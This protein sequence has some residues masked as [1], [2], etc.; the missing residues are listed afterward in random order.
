[1]N[2]VTQSSNGVEVFSFGD[3]EPVL[4]GRQIS[5]LFQSWHNG[6]YYEPPV[7][8][9]GLSKARHANSF[10]ESA[11]MVK[12][13][14]LSSCYKGHKLLSRREFR[15]LA[16]DY[17]AFGNAYLERV[18]NGLREP[19]TLTRTLAKM[20]RIKKDGSYIFLSDFQKEHAFKRNSIFHFKEPDLN[21][22]IYGVPQYL[23]GLQSAFLNEEATLFR[24]RYYQN[25]SHAGFILHISDAAMNDGDID[26]I[27]QALK[28]A[29]GVGNFKNLFLY[30]PNGKENG[31]KVIPIAEVMAKDEF[32]NIKNVSRD[33]VLSVHRVPPHLMGLVPANVGGFGN[34]K[35]AASVFSRNEIEPLKAVFQDINEWIGEEVIAFNDYEL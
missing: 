13:N 30:T 20:V 1:M 19:M 14:V 8:F 34:P 28:D 5:S 27:R 25:G 35:D 15:S 10:H 11:M 22:E 16:L 24:R 29:K 33:D 2:D 6:R 21:Q 12:V 31:V 32:F 7:D 3:P 17:I 9:E 26:G 18:E 4:N 23:S